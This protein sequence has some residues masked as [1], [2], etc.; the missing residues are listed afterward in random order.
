M[1]SGISPPSRYSIT[2]ANGGGR[3]VDVSAAEQDD[4]QTSIDEYADK[5]GITDR[6]GKLIDERRQRLDDVLDEE[7]EVE[8]SHQFGSHTRGTMVGPLDQDSDT[9]IMV[10]LD[11]SEHGQW[12]QDENGARNCLQAVRRAL[13]KRY[14][15][16]DVSI[17]RNVV[18][19]KF[20][21]FT[22]EVAPAFRTRNGYVIPDSYSEGQSWMKTNPRQ[23]KNQFDAV[24]Q[25]RGGRLQKVARIAKKFNDSNGSPV[26]SYHAEVMAYHYVRTHPNKDASTTELVEGFFEQLPRRISNGTREPV[27]DQRIDAEMDPGERREAIEMARE[28]REHVRRASRLRR[29]GDADAADKA[30]HEAIGEGVDR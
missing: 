17:D 12:R 11:E 16:S 3:G 27:Y 19:V 21:D 4:D 1:G 25:A 8:G 23:Y 29:E 15:N 5:A 9:D 28:A 13:D 2:G 30:Y 22:A 20:H 7:L 18:A 24:D 10:V 6:Q 26:S 14:P